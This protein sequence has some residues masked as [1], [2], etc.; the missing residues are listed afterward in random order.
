MQATTEHDIPSLKPFWQQRYRKDACKSWHRFYLRNRNHFFKD[1]HWLSKEFAGILDEPH[2][3]GLEL[4]CGT[5]SFV[6]PQLEANTTC[7]F[8]CCDFAQSAIDMV[9][10][11]PSYASLFEEGRLQ[12]FVANIVPSST[13]KDPYPLIEVE[14]LDV[15]SAIYVLSAIPPEDHAAV[16]RGIA[17]KLKPGGVVVLRDYHRGDESQVRFQKQDEVPK[18]QDWLYVRQ[19]GTLTWFFDA[20]EFKQLVLENGFSVVEQCER[21]EKPLENVKLGLSSKRFYLQAVLRK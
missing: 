9:K 11:H 7:R 17:G 21:I 5:G 16:L 18:L 19:D 12:A 14:S 2:I 8:Y 1:R 15:V 13:I 3:A 10:Q 6:F 20:D 4:G